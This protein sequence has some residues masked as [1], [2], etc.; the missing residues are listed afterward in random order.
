MSDDVSKR[1]L[2]IVVEGWRTSSAFVVDRLLGKQEV[3]IKAIGQLFLQG[4]PAVAG[5]AILGDGRVGL[6]LD[7]HGSRWGG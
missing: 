4:Q 5:G 3:V 7:V 2:G 6:I 1:L